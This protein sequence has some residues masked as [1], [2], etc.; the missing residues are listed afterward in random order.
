MLQEA[1]STTWD[2][3]N[4]ERPTPIATKLYVLYLFAVFLVASVKLI[5]VWRRA[6]P[7][8]LSSKA[9]SPDYLQVL[10]ASS[11]SLGRWIETTFLVWGIFASVS[12]YDVC[13]RLLLSKTIGNSVILFVIQDFS[14]TFTMALLIVLFLY[15]VRWHML[16]RIERLHHA[17]D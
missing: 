1:T 5:R 8:R 15:L 13:D 17:P 2:L 16:K 14:T 3:R 4:I 10:E 11:I 6:L 12:L 7:F 9:C